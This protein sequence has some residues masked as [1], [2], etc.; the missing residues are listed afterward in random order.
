MAR[1]YFVNR[2]GRLVYIHT[3]IAAAGQSCDR[4]QSTNWTVGVGEK[5]FLSLDE[6]DDACWAYATSGVVNDANLQLCI[7]SPGEKIDLDGTHAC[8]QKG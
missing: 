3:R 4:R 7:A 1:I 2:M 5:E 6:S 8:Y